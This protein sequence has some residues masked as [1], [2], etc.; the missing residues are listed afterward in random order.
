[1]P[2]SLADNYPWTELVAVQ[3]EGHMACLAASGG[4]QP[5]S[6]DVD[7]QGDLPVDALTAPARPARARHRQPVPGSRAAEQERV[8]HCLAGLTGRKTEVKRCCQTVLQPRAE[9]L[10]QNSPN[11]LMSGR[12]TSH[13]W[14]WIKLPLYPTTGD[15]D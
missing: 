10:L 2:N 3:D 4:N 5:P 15:S 11:P 8:R 7:V 6:V 13:T 12:C 9:I 1:M 14:S